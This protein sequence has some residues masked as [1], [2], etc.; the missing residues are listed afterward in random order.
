MSATGAP[1]WRVAD[2]QETTRVTAAGRFE[3]VFEFTVETDWGGS[4]KVQ[5]PK[6]VYSPDV[7]QAAAEQLYQSLTAGRFLSG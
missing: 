3:D 5:I 1:S 6:A 2:V 4:F 7:L